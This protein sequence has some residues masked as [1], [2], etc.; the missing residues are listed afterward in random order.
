MCPFHIDFLLASDHLW[1]TNRVTQF[2]R[3]QFTYLRFVNFNFSLAR[4]ND[5]PVLSGR[6]DF[7]IGFFLQTNSQHFAISK[8]HI[9]KLHDGT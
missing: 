2:F 8:F 4:Q 7:D 5:L 9:L 3:F 6:H 1:S